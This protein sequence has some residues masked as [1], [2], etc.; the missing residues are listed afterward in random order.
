[1][2]TPAS[3]RL[4]IG[5]GMALVVFTSDN[6]GERFSDNWPL[7][8]GKM[9]LTEGGIRVPWI[10]QWPALIAP[11]VVTAQIVGDIGG[12]LLAQPSGPFGLGS[13]T[14]V[15][16]IMAGY[17]QSVPAELEEAAR[18]DGK[19]V[20]TSNDD[21]PE[22]TSGSGS[23]AT[24]R[25]ASSASISAR[26]PASSSGRSDARRRWRIRSPAP[27][28]I[29]AAAVASPTASAARVTTCTSTTS[30]G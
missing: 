17:F 20:I 30:T 13:S 16:W 27:G 29:S 3:R 1:M 21:T 28:T 2:R 23:P 6:G 22:E 12:H 15:V 11:G 4:P 9:D 7:V 10:A 18:F 26:I 14:L 24:L 8:G 5:V 25:A 19:W